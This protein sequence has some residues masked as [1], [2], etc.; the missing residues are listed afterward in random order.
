MKISIELKTTRKHGYI[1][2][3]VSPQRIDL[4]NQTSTFS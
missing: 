4:S 1:A 3:D 2:Y